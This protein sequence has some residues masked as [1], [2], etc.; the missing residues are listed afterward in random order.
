MAR[1][2]NVNLGVKTVLIKIIEHKK[3]CFP[4]ISM[5]MADGTESKQTVIFR[6][7]MMP[8]IEFQS[9]FIYSKMVVLMKI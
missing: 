1:N 5:C 3:T 9:R 8:K 2:L 4:V 6:R 7:K